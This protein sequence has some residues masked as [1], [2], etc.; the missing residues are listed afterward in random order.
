MIVYAAMLSEASWD[1]CFS[2]AFPWS[3]SLSNKALLKVP[4]CHFLGND[5]PLPS[6]RLCVLPQQKNGLHSFVIPLACGY[7]LCIY[8]GSAFNEIVSH[9]WLSDGI[10]SAS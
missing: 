7:N 4:L 5:T 10:S 8:V 9:N 1:L 2:C 3:F 6:L